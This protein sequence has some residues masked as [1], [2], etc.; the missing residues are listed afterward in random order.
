MSKDLVQKKD[1]LPANSSGNASSALGSDAVIPK[2]LLMQGLSELVANRKAQQGDMVRSTTAEKLGDDKTPVEVIPLTIQ[3]LWMNQEKIGNKYEFRGY[4]P[5]TV[6]NEADPWEYTKNGTEWKRTKVLNLFALLPADIDA[7]AAEI[8]RFHETGEIPD[9]DKALL[10]VVI[11][12][13]NTSFAA[14]RTVSTLFLK[15]D[16]LSRQVGKDVPVYGKTLLLKCYQDKN[17]KGTYFVFEV[18]AAGKKTDPKYMETAS[19]WYN[20]LRAAGM[21]VRVDESDANDSAGPAPSEF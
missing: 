1:S 3:N 19:T 14:G 21:D 12:F 16:S 4:E 8:D 7:Q 10:P 11:P 5:R 18:D 9:A 6:N 2:I 13:R 17:D 15:A 20:T